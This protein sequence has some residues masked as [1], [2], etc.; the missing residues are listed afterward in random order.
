MSKSPEPISPS[1]LSDAPPSYT[2]SP[3][4]QPDSSQFKH[5]SP[6]SIISP[7]GQVQQGKSKQPAA[8]FIDDGGLPE[9]VDLD[10]Q[11]GNDMGSEGLIPVESLSPTIETPTE[12]TVTPLELLGDQS[13]T[14]DC[15]FCRQRV[16]TV[17][18][19]EASYMTHVTATTLFLTTIAGG[20]APYHYKWKS[21][22][23][24]HCGNCGR[25]VAYR[26][27]GKKETKALGTPDHLRVASKFPA[28]APQSVAK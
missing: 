16:E 15:P 23:S 27:Y 19:K 14:V 2:P 3:D 11:K 22:I 28:A 8:P 25:K 18:K 12:A 17:V 10:N 4:V 24:H 9:V 20:A 1:V 6:D 5:F 26:K 21:N 7:S 13:D